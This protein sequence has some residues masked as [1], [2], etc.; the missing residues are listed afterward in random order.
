MNVIELFKI[1]LQKRKSAAKKTTEHHNLKSPPAREKALGGK[2][3]KGREV[4]ELHGDSSPDHFGRNRFAFLHEFRV[5]F[6]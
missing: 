2:K 4:G 1:V 5:E 6:W 3:E